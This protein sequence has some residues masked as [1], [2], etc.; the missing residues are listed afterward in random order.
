M[1]FTPEHLQK[2]QGTHRVLFVG[3]GPCGKT[4]LITALVNEVHPPNTCD[5]LP[6]IGVDVTMRDIDELG[7]M[8]LWEL[9]GS[10]KFE[11]LLNALI[12]TTTSVG[13]V[14][15][16]PSSIRTRRNGETNSSITQNMNWLQTLQTNEIPVIHCMSKCDEST[17]EDRSFATKLGMIQIS[18]E[19]G[20]GIDILKHHIYEHC[21]QMS[22]EECV[23]SESDNDTCIIPFCCC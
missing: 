5:P 7:R 18:V 23:D 6:T 12:T 14:L 8:H 4:R 17:E 19:T 20:K 10:S 15:W 13:V 9:S 2:K 11:K 22:R 16:S 21:I 1:A 3:S